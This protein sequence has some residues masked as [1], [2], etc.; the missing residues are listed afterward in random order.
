M[1]WSF[2]LCAVT[3]Q[4]LWS[5][6]SVFAG[7]MELDAAEAVCSN[8]L[9]GPD[10]LDVVTSL[11]DKSILIRERPGNVVRFRLLEALREYGRDK[12]QESGEGLI[13]SRRH[14]DWY[15]KLA[16]AAEADWISPRQVEWIARLDRERRNLRVA[17]AVCID[18][19]REA[20]LALQMT[21]ALYPFWFSR[22]LLTEG[23]REREYALNCP[24]GRPRAH[25]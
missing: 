15:L 22:G 25:A 12:L 24:H 3:E 2:A 9:S 20:E 5:R 10:F 13:V 23:R 14:R 1:D 21:I 17:L 7:G 16:L 8:G 4:S 6:L 18:V 11:V 19:A